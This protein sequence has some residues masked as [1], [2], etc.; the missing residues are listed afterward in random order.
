MHETCQ[1]LTALRLGMAGL[2]GVFLKKNKK[3]LNITQYGRK[4]SGL[5]KIKP[6]QYS[7]TQRNETLMFHWK[8][9]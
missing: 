5:I 6:C 1:V 7:L 2:Y 9:N 4:Y 8:K 3:A